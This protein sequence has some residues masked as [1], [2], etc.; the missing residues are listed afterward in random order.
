[1]TSIDVHQVA[2]E[3]WQAW[4]EIR[5]RSL[6]QDPDAFGSTYEREAAFD[7]T[8][9]RS[10]L[11]GTS[12]PAVL[13]YAGEVPVGMG[14]GWLGEPGRLMVVSMWTDPSWRGR[15]VGTRVLEH[16]VGWAAH[17][18][19]RVHL[20]VADANPGAR[21]LYE[22]HGFRGDGRS[23][24]LRDGSAVTKSHLVLSRHPHH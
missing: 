7:E 8:T 14:A 23:E 15:G 16:V 24:P 4:R 3:G 20:W 1:M 18:E 9:W 22:R 13:G 11:D 19:L 5:L 21:R 2:P 10:W 17:R 6:A 12:G